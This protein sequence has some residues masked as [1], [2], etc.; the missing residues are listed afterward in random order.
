MQFS[1]KSKETLNGSEVGGPSK[2]A[3]PVFKSYPENQSNNQVDRK[4]WD[5]VNN[6]DQSASKKNVL[7]VTNINEA[8]PVVA[9]NTA[10]LCESPC[11]LSEKSVFKKY[12]DRLGRNEYINIAT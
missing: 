3:K 5:Y 1:R 9:C 4:K 11:E 7:D 12:L 8:L 10:Q 2:P 6:S